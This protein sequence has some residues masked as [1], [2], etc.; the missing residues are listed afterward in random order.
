M[1]VLV[2]FAAVAAVVLASV[3][4]A[5]GAAA[6]FPR[7]PRGASVTSLRELKARGKQ[8]EVAGALECE[9]CEWI[10]TQVEALLQQNKSVSEIVTTLDKACA[11][12]GRYLFFII[13]KHPDVSS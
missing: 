2:L 5:E 9:I 8:M 6:S 3:S 4:G 11:I 7:K 12:F 1:R 10:V 13:S